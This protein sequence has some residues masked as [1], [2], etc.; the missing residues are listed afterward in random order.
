VVRSIKKHGL[1][2]VRGGEGNF[3]MCKLPE[4]NWKP[5]YNY[6]KNTIVYTAAAAAVLNLSLNFPKFPDCGLGNLPQ[7]ACPSTP[8]EATKLMN[9]KRTS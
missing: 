1:V 9:L 4:E 7:S 3:R 6:L 2:S 8:Y 5:I